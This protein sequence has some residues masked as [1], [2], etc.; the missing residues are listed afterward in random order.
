[1][2]LGCLAWRA[3]QG[4]NLVLTRLDFAWFSLLYWLRNIAT[5]VSCYLIVVPGHLICCL[6][7][8]L[9]RGM[10]YCILIIVTRQIS[11]ALRIYA[12]I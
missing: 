7:I 4:Q 2:L 5:A 12:Q 6:V 8:V 1:L 10:A 3:W 9:Y 11:H